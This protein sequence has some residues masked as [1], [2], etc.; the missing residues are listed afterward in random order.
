MWFA[1]EDKILVKIL[2]NIKG[3]NVKDLVREFP[4]KVWNV[5]HVY[6]LLQK[7]RIT[8]SVDYCPGSGRR[9]TPDNIDLV[10]ELVLHKK[11]LHEK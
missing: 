1:K 5:G 9:R 10:Y 7:L 11:W 6:K 3:Y 4:S 8:G 2:F